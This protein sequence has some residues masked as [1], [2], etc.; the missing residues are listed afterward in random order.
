MNSLAEQ[1]RREIRETGS[2]T[3]ARF[4]AV[5]LYAPGVGYYEQ[6]RGPGRAGDFFTSVSVGPLFGR[7]LAFQFARW[8]DRDLPE[9]Q[10]RIAEA[11]AHDGRLAA[12]ILAWLEARRPDLLER[13]EVL[14][15]R[16]L[17]RAEAV[18][19]RD[20]AP[21]VASHCLG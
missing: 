3:F 8:L 16:S 21:L 18:A 9:G 1:L 2:I 14:P 19:G 7:L 4:M 10:V 15:T 6:A 5:A 13:L 12:D 20:L 11:G 17:T